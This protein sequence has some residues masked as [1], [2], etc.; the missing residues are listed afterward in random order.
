[1]TKEEACKVFGMTAKE[2][3]EMLEYAAHRENMDTMN[4]LLS[5][6]SFDKRDLNEALT[7][8]AV[9]GQNNMIKLLA[10]HGA[11]NFDQ[12]M[13]TAAFYGRTDTVMLLHKLGASDFTEALTHARLGQNRPD[14]VGLLRMYMAGHKPRSESAPAP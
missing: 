10:G 6:V 11:D 8:A 4:F 1:M 13:S 9:G 2:M 12:A 3:T 7:S 14:T 5:K